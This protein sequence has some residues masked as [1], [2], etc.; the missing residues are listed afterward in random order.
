MLGLC[1]SG[2]LLSLHSS[3]DRSTEYSH[4]LNLFDAPDMHISLFI[5]RNTELQTME[6][7]LQPKSRSLTRRVLILGGTGGIG[8]T[9]LCIN[10]AKRHVNSYSSIFWLDASSMTSIKNSLRKLANRL[11]PPDVVSKLDDAGV[12]IRVSNWLSE[13]DNH[14]WLLILDNYDEPGEYDIAQFYP[15]V[16]HGSLVITTRQPHHVR[17]EQLKIELMTE[18]NDGLAVLATRSRR[19]G[20]QS[21]KHRHGDW[22]S[23]PLIYH[24]ILELV[25]SHKG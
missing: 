16:A 22:S 13:L 6:E 12:C 2:R 11:L 1:L 18:V 8:K 21:G 15:S 24:Q 14:R 20:V 5:G 9:Q 4:G 23:Q 10:Y 25:G 19:Q 3:A 7:V 17:G